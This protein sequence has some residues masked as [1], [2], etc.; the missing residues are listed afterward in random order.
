M[1]NESYDYDDDFEDAVDAFE[2]KDY[3]TAYKL[4]LPL[5]EPRVDLDAFANKHGDHK[6][7]AEAQHSMGIMY[8]GGFGVEQDYKE[9]VKWWKLAA[10][11]GN[12]KAQ[13]IVAT[14]HAAK[15]LAGKSFPDRPQ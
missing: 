1:N 12:A 5:A 13:F 9:A 10:E 2:R 8:Y 11:Q 15:Q 6:G 7:I 3:E 4:F 14:R